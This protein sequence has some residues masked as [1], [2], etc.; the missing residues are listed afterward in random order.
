MSPQFEALWDRIKQKNDLPRTIDREKNSLKIASMS[1]ET[2]R[3]SKA[4]LVSQTADIDIQSAGVSHME[5][6]LRTTI[7]RKHTTPCRIFCA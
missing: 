1:C 3:H 7:Y 2:C 5:R 6:E 4:R